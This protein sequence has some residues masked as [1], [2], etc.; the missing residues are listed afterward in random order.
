MGLDRPFDLL[1]PFRD[2]FNFPLYGVR[3]VSKIRVD[4]CLAY[5]K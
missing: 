4:A 5:K 1:I 2:I 3:Y